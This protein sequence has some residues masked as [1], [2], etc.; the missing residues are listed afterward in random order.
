MID[1]DMK[2]IFDSHAH[3]DNKAFDEDRHEVLTQLPSQGVCGVVNCGTDRKTS[4]D[5]LALSDRYPFIF[6]ACG[7][8]PHDASQ[9]DSAD[10]V[11]ELPILTTTKKCIAI[12]E[13]GLDYHYDFSPRDVQQAIFEAQLAIAVEQDLPVIVHNR[14]AHEDTL[15][16]LEKY[17][18]RGV[19]HSFSGSVETMEIIIKLGMY[20]GLGG[21]VTFKNAKTPLEVARFVPAERLLIETDAPYMTPVPFRGKRCS[22]ALIPYTA[23]KIAEIRGTTA[24]DVLDLTARNAKDLFCI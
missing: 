6:A 4:E 13:I 16:L 18:P 11:K 10:F 17:K 7:V 19:L 8:H 9:E 23:E 5:S 2:N 15:R 3:Y 14:Q 24:Q 20:I 21:V 12:G 22:S 1:I